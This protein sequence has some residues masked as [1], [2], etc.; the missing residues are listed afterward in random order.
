MEKA[1]E[2]VLVD[3]GFIDRDMLNKTIEVHRL[4]RL[5]RVDYPSALQ[6]LQNDTSIERLEELR[7]AASADGADL[8]LYEFLRLSGYFANGKLS[9]FVGRMAD[10][11]SL[12]LELMSSQNIQIERSL[13]KSVEKIIENSALL[14]TALS[15]CY[16]SDR[17]LLSLSEKIVQSVNSNSMTVEG[18][19]L[20]YADHVQLYKV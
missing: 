18:G 16:P 9:S 1:A 12:M 8:S 13:R 14:A 6:L 7:Q 4:L 17:E 20:D 15:A 19:L 3:A 11:K 10:D 2:E 5:N